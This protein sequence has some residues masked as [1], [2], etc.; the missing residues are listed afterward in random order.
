MTSEELIVD[1]LEKHQ[2]ALICYARSI[3]GDIESA[4]DAVQETFLKLSRQDVHALKDRI[5]A[6][7]FRVCR[8]C[9]LD[10]KRKII[11]MPSS[12]MN[13]WGEECDDQPNPSETALSKDDS[14]QVRRLANLLP[15][16]QRELVE[17]KFSAGLSYREMSEVTGLSVSNVGF[18]LHDAIARLRKMWGEASTLNIVKAYG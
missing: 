7:L 2:S 5:A 11:R 3:T 8:N 16:N 18:Q 12:S 17:L 1:A 9:A 15:E 14:S 13:G 6:W 4:R 10:Y